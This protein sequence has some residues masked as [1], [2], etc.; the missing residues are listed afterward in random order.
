MMNPSLRLPS[1]LWCGG[2]T[3]L[4][5]PDVL[6]QAD[7]RLTFVCSSCGAEMALDAETSAEYRRAADAIVRN[8]V[9][10][11]QQW[12]RVVQ[13]ARRQVAAGTASPELVA[14]LDHLDAYWADPAASVEVRRDA[15]A[16]V[17]RA[18]GSIER[19]PAV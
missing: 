8:A 12:A 2:E 6:A 17:L 10:L 13:T 18:L 4:A 5:N 7:A 14:A 11:L 1:C 9:D 16:R 3:A 15:V 19:G